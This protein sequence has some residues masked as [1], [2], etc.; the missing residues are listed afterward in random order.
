MLWG[1]K[2]RFFFVKFSLSLLVCQATYMKTVTI[3]I[4]NHKVHTGSWN[5]PSNFPELEKI[6]VKSWELFLKVTRENF[7]VLAKSYSIS[8]VHLQRIMEM[9]FF[10]HFIKVSIDHL[11]DN[12]EY[13]KRNYC[14]GKSLEKGLE[15]WIQKSVRT[16]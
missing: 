9:L 12:L 4:C 13:G 1:S 2:D 14:F 7:F 5:F 11:F 10:L 6:L 16:L 8:F 15:F 3:R